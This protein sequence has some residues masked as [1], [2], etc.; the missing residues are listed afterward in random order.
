MGIAEMAAILRSAGTLACAFLV[1]LFTAGPVLLS[2]F[3][4]VMPDR[5]LFGDHKNILRDAPSL[6]TYRYIF[7]GE[8]PEAYQHAGANR[9]MISE[10]ARQVPRGLWNSLQIALSAMV[11]NLAIG[12]PAAFVYGRSE[13]PG[14]RLTFMF[15][16]LAPLMPA[17]ALV[18]P[19]Y[20]MIQAAGLLGTKSS[21][22]ILHT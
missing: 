4:S 13:F 1:L 20:M 15:L 11:L 2:L 21:I 6:E 12:A 18:T 3:A 16:L 17:V 7:T 8:V 14:K 10:A 9:A 22:V 19:I 5:V